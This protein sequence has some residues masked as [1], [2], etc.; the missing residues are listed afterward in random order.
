MNISTNYFRRVFQQPTL[1]ENDLGNALLTNSKEG[2]YTG[3]CFAIDRALPYFCNF[4]P[5]KFCVSASFAKACAA[6]SGAISKIVGGGTGRKVVR[7]LT[8]RIVA[9]VQ[10]VKTV[11]NRANKQDVRSAMRENG[12]RVS[13][14]M[15]YSIAMFVFARLPKPAVVT[16]SNGDFG[17]KAFGEVFGKTLFREIHR[18]SVHLLE[19]SLGCFGPRS[20]LA[21]AR[22]HFFYMMPLATTQGGI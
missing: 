20:R 3:L 10:Y 7:I 4:H 8:P 14:G 9:T 5:S 18:A 11:W 13:Y 6:F 19:S 17:Y 12:S 22:G 21:R 2:G 15:N 16:V 1:I